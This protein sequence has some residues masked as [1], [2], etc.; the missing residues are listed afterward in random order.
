[1]STAKRMISDIANMPIII[2]IRPMPPSSSVLPNV[3][4]GKPAGLESPTDATSSPSI[5]DTKPLSGRSDVMN[6]A[7][8]RPS[9]TS[10]KYSNELN[11]SA[12]SAS[13]GA[14][15]STAVPK[16]P[17]IA[18]KTRPAPSAVSACPFLVIA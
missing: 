16:S 1:M 18:E 10:Q 6:T 12:N 13:A 17:P 11:L 8:V 14:A 2:G 5:S 4:R 9:S 7:Q 3:K 15:M